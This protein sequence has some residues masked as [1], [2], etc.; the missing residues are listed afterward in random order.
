LN[1]NA[2]TKLYKTWY[3]YHGTWAHLNCVLHK[4]LPPVCVSGCVSLL[5]L[6]GKGSVKCIPPFIARQRLDKHIPAATNTRN[7]RR[8]VRRVIFCAVRDLSKECQWVCLSIPLSLLCNN[9]VTTFSRQRRIV[10][11]VV[12]YAV[13]VVSKQIR[14]LVALRTFC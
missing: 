1:L 13:R 7:S 6:L 5:S 2:W 11:S 12:L 9:S 10:G 14:R 3:V 4:S 8:T